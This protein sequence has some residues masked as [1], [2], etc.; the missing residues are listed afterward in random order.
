MEG[1]ALWKL[2]RESLSGIENCYLLA[3]DP[4]VSESGMGN[5]EWG[6]LLAASTFEPDPTTPGHLMVRGPY[7]AAEQYSRLLSN[8]ADRGYFDEL[9]DGQFRL[10][11][12]GRESVENYVELARKAMA[13]SDPLTPETSL[14]LALALNRLVRQCLETPPPPNVWS[15]RL[16]FKLMPSMDPA[17]PY[18]E[19]AISCLVAYRD[20]AHLASWR[21]SGLPATALETLTILWRKQAKTLDDLVERLEHRGHPRMV[22]ADALAELRDRN[23]VTGVRSD[24]R[25]TPEGVE[26][27]NGIEETTDRLFFTPWLCLNQS[28]MEEMAGILAQIKDDLK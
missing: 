28:E 25:I 19:Q 23:F 8:A 7:T 20:D 12:L 3:V 16:S 5:R 22:Y 13:E 26:F 1:H 17:L 24:I 6:L 14:R 15:I 4:L 2:M 9:A 11:S 10:T 21:N 27:R 18:I